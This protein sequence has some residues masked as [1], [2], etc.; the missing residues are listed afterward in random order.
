MAGAGERPRTRRRR[1]RRQSRGSSAHSWAYG[2]AAGVTGARA[3]A[4]A[5][6][7]ACGRDGRSPG[8]RRESMPGWRRTSG[9]ARTG[10]RTR[11][12]DETGG[13]AAVRR[14][15]LEFEAQLASRARR[16]GQP[17]QR[18]VAGAGSARRACGGC[19]RRARRWRTDRRGREAACATAARSAARPRLVGSHVGAR[20]EGRHRAQ[21]E[22]QAPSW[23]RLASAKSVR[24]MLARRA[25]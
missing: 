10:G 22:G 24:G 23:R 16:R 5:T 12:G 21:E 20:R 1:G 19:R 9:S 11:D 18:R 8:V 7:A 17:P 2:A 4:A 3:M 25:A 15:A 6:E 14:L 13:A